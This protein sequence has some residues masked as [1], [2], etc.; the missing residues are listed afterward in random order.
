MEFSEVRQNTAG[1][2]DPADL[3]QY[4]RGATFPVSIFIGPRTTSPAA[5]SATLSTTTGTLHMFRA[6]ETTT[7]TTLGIEL[8]TFTANAS[9]T[10]E[11]FTHGT[12]G[13]D[14]TTVIPPTLGSGTTLVSAAAI[15]LSAAGINEYT[16][17]TPFAITEG[18]LYC[19]RIL[20]GSATAVGAVA[21]SAPN[22]PLNLYADTGAGRWQS[23]TVASIERPGNLLIWLK[24]ASGRVIGRPLVLYSAIASLGTNFRTFTGGAANYSG[25]MVR[26]PR[27]TRVNGIQTSI[28]KVL[29][30]GPCRMNVYQGGTL[31]A[32]SINTCSSTDIASGAIQ[33]FQFSNL[34]LNRD[35]DYVFAVIVDSGTNDATN[36]WLWNGAV[37]GAGTTKGFPFD[38]YPPRGNPFY[39]ITG[40]YTATNPTNFAA[41]QDWTVATTSDGL[42]YFRLLCQQV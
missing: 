37:A 16:L 1:Q 19:I 13:T 12:G 7:I 36:Y 42:P 39:G 17:G 27:R 18:Q 14:L 3:L 35:I 10:I 5:S 33:S 8:V 40:V 34:I 31:I 28:G 9:V 22:L 25:V 11:I 4:G 15:G 26:M 32:Q 30:P 24:T 6:R 29:S 23:S 2:T 20:Q 38:I 41:G 21:F